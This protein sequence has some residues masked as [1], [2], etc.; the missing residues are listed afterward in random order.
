MNQ[1]DKTRVLGNKGSPWWLSQTW[2]CS[3]PT[4]AL[5]LSCYRLRPSS[6]SFNAHAICC[7]N[8][9]PHITNYT[10]QQ[11]PSSHSSTLTFINILLVSLG[12]RDFISP[13]P[14]KKKSAVV[15]IQ[16]SNFHCNKTRFVLGSDTSGKTNIAG[17]LSL[18]LPWLQSHLLMIGFIL[19]Y[20]WL[21]PRLPEAV[22]YEW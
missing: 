1:Q 3:L 13:P 7:F 2:P 15:I 18:M 14:P 16:E 17:S 9:R 11:C 20:R 8:D 19:C 22:W 4:V 6:L 10:A 21:H 12:A 5:W